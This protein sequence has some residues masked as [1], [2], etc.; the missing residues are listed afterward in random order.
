MQS[1]TN[2]TL[3]IDKLTNRYAYR[4]IRGGVLYLVRF[5][6][7]STRDTIAALLYEM[8]LAGI[9]PTGFHYCDEQ[10]TLLIDFLATE[11]LERFCGIILGASEEDQGLRARI[12]GRS[13]GGIAGWD[14]DFYLWKEA[15][16][17][18]NGACRV[19]AFLPD[20][21]YPR[22]RVRASVVIPPEDVLR[23]LLRL[24]DYNRASCPI[25]AGKLESMS[26]G[27]T[28]HF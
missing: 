16:L 22:Q 4:A 26:C 23:V 2:S 18:L 5:D 24:R 8:Q 12:G 1:T 27:A 13:A 9:A 21:D 25:C 20:T 17:E 15:S 10:G 6:R 11:D 14:Y 7:Q 3:S 28:G 19:D